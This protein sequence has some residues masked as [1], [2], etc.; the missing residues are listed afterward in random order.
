M[1][2]DKRNIEKILESYKDELMYQFVMSLDN[3]LVGYTACR[4]RM[5]A[6]KLS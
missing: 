4:I 1:K 5:I 3:E 2:R 6:E